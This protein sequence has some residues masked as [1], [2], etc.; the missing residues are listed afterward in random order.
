MTKTLQDLFKRYRRPG[1][2][3]FAALFLALSL[4]LLWHLPTQAPWAKGDGIFKNPAFWPSVAIAAMVVFS[5]FH[6][7]GAAVSERIPGRLAEVLYWLRA[8][9]YVGWF[10]IYVQAVPWLGYLPSTIAFCALLSFRLGYRS[11]RV[12]GAAA[13]FGIAVVL[14][15]KTFLQVK[16]PAGEVYQLLPAAARNFMMI[17]F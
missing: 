14:L 12:L 10:M 1:D 15:F 16:V 5:A 17:Y 8:F 7:L 2:M 9:E 6:L 11:R 3:V 4:F 13:L